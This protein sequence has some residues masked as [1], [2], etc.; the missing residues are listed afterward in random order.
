V[1]C[2]ALRDAT[3]ASVTRDRRRIEG[4]GLAAVLGVKYH[5]EPRAQV[6]AAHVGGGVALGFDPW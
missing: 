5:L 4:L 3:P 2:C 6:V 1:A